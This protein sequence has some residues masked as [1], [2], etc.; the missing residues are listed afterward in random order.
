MAIERTE[1]VLVI[2][3][4]VIEIF[5]NRYRRGRYLFE[6]QDNIP[7]RIVISRAFCYHVY[8]IANK[9]YGTVPTLRD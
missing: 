1:S 7:G 2:N 9:V 8:K 4:R 3:R 6:D 5:V